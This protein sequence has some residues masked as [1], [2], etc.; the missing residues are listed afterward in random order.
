[1]GTAQRESG[2]VKW[3]SIPVATTTAVT[4]RGA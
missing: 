1:M 2:G 4:V 3:V